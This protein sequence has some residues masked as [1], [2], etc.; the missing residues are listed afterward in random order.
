[1]QPMINTA[2]DLESRDVLK[3]VWVNFFQA[4]GIAGS[5]SYKPVLS[6]CDEDHSIA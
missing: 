3:Q 4:N 1:M 5:K 6:S 2:M